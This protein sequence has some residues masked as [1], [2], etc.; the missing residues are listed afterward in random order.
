M[1]TF[2][3][4]VEGSLIT[5]YWEQFYSISSSVI[6]KREWIVKSPVSQMRTSYFGKSNTMVMVKIIKRTSVSEKRKKKKKQQISFRPHNCKAGKIIQVMFMWCWAQNSRYNSGERF[7]SSL[8]AAC[9]YLFNKEWHHHEQYWAQNKKHYFATI[10]KTD[11]PI[12]WVPCV[13]LISASQKS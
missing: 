10:W 1:V 5:L 13:V 8:T 2:E 9:N 12:S 4:L 3:E 11:V 6:W 7:H